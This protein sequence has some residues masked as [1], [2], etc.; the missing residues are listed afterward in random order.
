MFV[1]L[2][3]DK[4]TPLERL[5]T[6][7]ANSWSCKRQERAVGYGPMAS[8]VTDAMPP[9]L[10]KPMVQFGVRAGVVRKLR[11]GNLMISNVPGPDFPL[12]FAGMR[13]EAVYPMGPVVDG[14]A[15]NITVQSYEDTLYV[16][17]NSGASALPDLPRLASAMVD[18]LALLSLMARGT[19]GQARHHRPS[20]RCGGHSIGP[21]ADLG[22]GHAGPRLG[23]HGLSHPTRAGRCV[24]LS[25]DCLGER[26]AEKS[27]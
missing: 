9:A 17:I 16:G 20:L 24:R 26:S 22:V 23:R 14:V 10:V 21:P 19:A 4:Q 7:K 6:V 5:R 1:P 11:A 25:G 2:A 13:M 3:N 15:L 18:E 12:Y 8:M 27:A